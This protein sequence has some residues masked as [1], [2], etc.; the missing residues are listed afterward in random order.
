MIKL[1]GQTDTDFTSNGDRVIIPFKAV[2]HKEDNGAFYLELETDTSYADDLIEGRIVV[3]PTPQG[4]QPFR[5][6]NVQ[7]TKHKILT[8]CQHVF[9]DT[10][11]YLIRQVTI[12]EKDGGVALDQLNLAATPE[13]PFT[14][15]SDVST[16][17]SMECNLMSLCEAIEGL[18][19]GWGGHLDLDGFTIGFRQNIGHDNGVV[20]RYAKN[21][22]DITCQENWD[23]VCTKI[24]PVGQDGIMLPEVY[25]ESPNQY[26]LPY[27]KTQNFDQSNVLRENYTD[28]AGNLDTEAYNNALIE[29]LRSKA[30]TYLSINALPQTNYT[31]SANLEKITDIGDTVIVKDERL[32]IDIET[33]VISYSYDCILDKYKELEF[34]NFKKKLSGLTDQI[35]QTAQ[36]V[37]DNTVSGIEVKL[38][39][40]LATAQEKIWG[41]LGSSYVIYE[42]DKILVVDKLPKSQAENVIMINNGGI[43]FSQTG[44]NG[45]FK[46]AWT[47]DNV[48]NAEMINVIN[49]SANLIKGGTLRLGANL[50]E[51]GTIEVYDEANSLIAILDKNGLKMNGKDGSYVL[52]NEEVGFA[53]YD[54]LGEKI[55]WVS[56]DE[57]HQK[58]S[59]IEEEITICNKLRHIGI[60]ITDGNDTIINDGVGIVAVSGGNQ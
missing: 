29:D 22:K 56:E 27:V 11:N 7:K 36:D 54:R 52:M 46:S 23:N 34:G 25:V 30:Q 26:D 38:S 41:A 16:I 53:G 58:K 40:E 51:Y 1:F 21:L 33:H 28:S 15:I 39:K 5:V 10:K 8:N 48:F 13:S 49:F 42:G 31:L 43:G 45:P 44:I 9:F 47:I 17:N 57:F 19:E 55:Y 12:N 18:V 2:V 60:T 20:V 37:A 59:V 50:N 14:T 4:E 32:S 24:L 6:S 35:Q 3:A